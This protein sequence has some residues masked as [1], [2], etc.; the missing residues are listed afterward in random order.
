MFSVINFLIF[1]IASILQLTIIPR[2]AIAGVFPNIVLVLIIVWSAVF[3]FKKSFWLAIVSGI[4]LD[5]FVGPYFGIFTVT[6]LVIAFLVDIV[7]R[8]IFSNNF[9]FSVLSFSFI[10]TI[11]TALLFHYL[12]F[13]EVSISYQ[14]I[15][16]LFITLIMNLSLAAIIL[17]L[18]NKFK[19]R[20]NIYEKKVRLP[21]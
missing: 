21:Y 18:I 15:L 1:F 6:F 7:T 16:I 2:L 11:F 9:I 3:G 8:Y 19:Y 20:I 12:A 4:L 14:F 17:P 5:L 13:K 10:A